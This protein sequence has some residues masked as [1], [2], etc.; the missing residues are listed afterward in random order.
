MNRPSRKL[1][2]FL[3]SVSVIYS[4]LLFII[5][6]TYYGSYGTDGDMYRMLRS[7]QDIRIFGE[8]SPSRFQGNPIAEIVF[9]VSAEL[10]GSISVLT[11]NFLFCI[12]S[13]L[14][15]ILLLKKYS[16][17]S[18]EYFYALILPLNPYFLSLIVNPMDYSIA[19]FCFLLG[20]YFLIKKNNFSL[21]IL[22]M[23][24]ASG[25]RIQYA[26]LASIILLLYLFC[27]EA[28]SLR[29][30]IYKFLS[31]W[32]NLFIF[33]LVIYLPSIIDGHMTFANFSAAIPVNQGLFGMIARWLYKSF[34]LFGGFGF[35]LL[36]L[37]LF[38]YI[39][40]YKVLMPSKNFK[41]PV[42][43]S[44]T[45]ILYNF[46]LFLTIPV[47]PIYIISSIFGIV[48]LSSIYLL[49]KKILGLYIIYILISGYLM[50]VPIKILHKD[51][52]PCGPVVATNAEIKLNFTNG[53][54][55]QTFQDHYKV[56][57]CYD[58]LFYPP[59]SLRNP[60]PVTK[61]SFPI[62]K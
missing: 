53:P 15:T 62:Q 16:N 26:P 51:T 18:D 52:G 4:F 7:W 32:L 20:L 27:I 36:L 49:S 56:S 30:K 2:I 11:L 17:N 57:K 40:N 48:M 38:K 22:S 59:R 5:F 10:G 31:L 42:L 33:C 21:F 23:A 60:L 14:L 39:K 47:D 24:L 3:F 44:L 1:Y 61:R 12:G 55:L 8:Y 9:G 45:I 13:I 25:A 37:A 54:V 43:I 29:N 19:L 46:I 6:L 50:L 58:D 41:I 28:G 34:L 35:L